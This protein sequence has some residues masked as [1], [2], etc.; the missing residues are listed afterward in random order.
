VEE[1]AEA[2][3]T[4]RDESSGQ[5]VR[6]SFVVVEGKEGRENKGRMVEGSWEQALTVGIS[7]T[8]PVVVRLRTTR[9][10]GP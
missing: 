2:R 8:S 3:K 5:V 7:T 6:S 9:Y 10:R 4:R 1:K